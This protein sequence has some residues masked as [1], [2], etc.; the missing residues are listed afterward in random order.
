[1]TGNVVTKCASHESEKIVCCVTRLGRMFDDHDKRL[2]ER[3]VSPFL[4]IRARKPASI[5]V[6]QVAHK[7]QDDWGAAKTG[8]EMQDNHDRSDSCG[9]QF[10][11]LSRHD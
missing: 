11:V 8:P 6:M 9:V 5:Y 7:R 10:V 1:M 2:V 4:E 3:G